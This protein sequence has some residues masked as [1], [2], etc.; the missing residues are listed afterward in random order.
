[1]TSS[2]IILVVLLDENELLAIK[3]FKLHA[4][5][6]LNRNKFIIAFINQPRI[7][8]IDFFE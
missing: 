3:L 5:I 8:A 7:V 1:L 4:S 6:S 2:H